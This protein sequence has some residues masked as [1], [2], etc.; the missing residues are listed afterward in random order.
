MSKKLTT[1]F[2][3]MLLVSACSKDAIVPEDQNNGEKQLLSF[4]VDGFSQNLL[5][6]VDRIQA[7]HLNASLF[8]QV[9]SSTINLSDYINT[10]EFM[11]YHRGIVVDSVRQFSDDPDFGKYE[12][13]FAPKTSVPYNVFI[14]G[15]MLE[16]DGDI[17]MKRKHGASQQETSLRILPEPVDAFSFANS[18]IIGAEPQT[19]SIQ[20]KR[21]VGRLEIDLKEEIPHNAA[22]IE[23]TVENTAQY[24]MPLLKKGY[25]LDPNKDSTQHNTL[26][27]IIF[28]A[29]DIGRTDYSA[30]VYYILKSELGSEAEISGV[31]LK[32][33]DRS[34]KEIATR[35]IP[36]VT[37]Q[38]NK[39]TRLTGKIFTPHPSTFFDIEITDDWDSEVPEFVF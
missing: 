9:S 28:Q 38:A 33:F 13:Y 8:S 14:A 30:T 29:E 39:R 7:A 12:N 2:I 4:T 17:E 37:L 10:L 3:F 27:T 23:I 21:F 5:P 32:A 24:F 26:K 34:N 19:E 6:F 1:A 15:A 31:T 11:V 36:D 20:L 18:Y 22:R 16:F 25:H 35:Y